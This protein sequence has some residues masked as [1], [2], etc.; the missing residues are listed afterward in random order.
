MTPAHEVVIRVG[1]GSG[2]ELRRSL[3]S[4]V[5]A[6]SLYLTQCNFVLRPIVVWLCPESTPPTGPRRFMSGH[7]LGMLEPS[8]VLQINRDTGCPPGVTSDWGQ[9]GT[10]LFSDKLA[11]RVGEGRVG[12]W[13]LDFS[14]FKK[15]G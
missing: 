14:G 4:I 11:G 6:G 9:S 2:G 1:E 5:T 15:L 10:R 12:D 8:V 13:Q 3:R 7:L